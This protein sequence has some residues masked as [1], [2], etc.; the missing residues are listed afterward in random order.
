[1]NRGKAVS[2]LEVDIE[3]P[4]SPRALAGGPAGAAP[5]VGDGA[6]GAAVGARDVR[7]ALRSLKQGHTLWY[8]PDQDYGPRHSVFVKF[9][10]VPA[11]TITATTRFA[12][13]NNSAVVFFSHY[14]RADNSGYHLDLSEALSDYPSGDENVYNRYAG[15]G[16][17]PI[18]SWLKRAAFAIRFG[19]A[20]LI[21]SD[22]ITTETRTLFHRQIQ[23][24][25]RLIAPYL[26]HDSDPYLVI[27]DGR[28]VWMLDTYTIS[29][30]MPYS[31]PFTPPAAVGAK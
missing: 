17:I 20:N 31:Q 15:T 13:L 22:Y 23:E 28:L 25:V 4:T 7:Q 29:N 21:L 8:A 2:T 26:W 10:G 14:R 16:G 27:S 1:M 9:F 30:D 6:G 11:A 19:D 24:R 12:S 3:I 5:G 18:D